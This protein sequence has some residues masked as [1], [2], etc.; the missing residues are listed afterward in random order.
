MLRELSKTLSDAEVLIPSHFILEGSQVGQAWSA[1]SKWVSAVP[2][3]LLPSTPMEPNSKMNDLSKDWDEADRDNDLGHC[4]SFSRI[5]IPLAF[6]QSLG[7]LC[8]FPPLSDRL[9]VSLNLLLLLAHWRPEGLSSRCYS[10]TP[11]LCDGRQVTEKIFSYLTT[12][13]VC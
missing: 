11:L 8:L 5:S 13:L 3:C 9:A 10:I 6:F 7:W 2:D 4:R 1:F 12:Y